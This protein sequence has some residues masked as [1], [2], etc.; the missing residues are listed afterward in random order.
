MEFA[1]HGNCT[2]PYGA[3]WI[4]RENDTEVSLKRC[5]HLRPFKVIPFEEFSKIDDVVEYAKN[6]DYLS[7][8]EY[9]RQMTIDRC[10]TCFFP[11]D[12]IKQVVISLSHACNIYCHNCFFDG[13]HKD[14]KQ[15][16]DLFFK[17]LY[18]L[19][20]HQLYQL[21]LTDQGE[22]FFY[23]NEVVKFL[24]SLTPNDT[25]TMRFFTN[26]TLLN[27]NRILELKKISE[28]TG[29]KYMF[30]AS[31]DGVTKESF[32]GTRCGAKWEQ[33]MENFDNLISTF[34]KKDICVSCTIR[35]ASICDLPKIKPF[36]D[37]KGI[38]VNIYYDMLD[39]N[40]KKAFYA[41]QG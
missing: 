38:E 23:Y 30:V 8:D 17:T 37:A 34:D 3:L 27:K 33:V 1:N 40:C 9:Q 5:C 13:H 6:F 19:K 20:G 31:I 32:E 16:K 21:Q 15:I 12:K 22:P 24:R 25:E 41:Y 28:E 18:G 10:K 36:F 11:P 7:P 4:T 26:M 35:E 14:T 29:V 39:E 2:I